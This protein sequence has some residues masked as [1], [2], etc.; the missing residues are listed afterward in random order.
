[1]EYTTI[2]QKLFVFFQENPVVL[3]IIQAVAVCRK[4]K[5][6]CLINQMGKIPYWNA[7]LSK[8]LPIEFPL[9][10]HGRGIILHA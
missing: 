7:V 10:I 2:R 3:D 9:V 5:P 1:M 6:I 4:Y 8:N